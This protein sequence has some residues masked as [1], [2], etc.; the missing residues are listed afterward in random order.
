MQDQLRTELKE[1]R[2]GFGVV[3]NGAKYL[4]EDRA[5]M[6]KAYDANNEEVQD[7]E[8]LKQLVELA[9]S[10][11]SWQLY[12]KC[13]WQILIGDTPILVLEESE[14]LAD[15]VEKRWRVL[16]SNVEKFQ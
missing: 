14:F 3:H 1:V 8:L 9:R 6:W 2:K 16:E 12:T 13:I 11:A 5:G 10:S 4:V 15:V 7:E